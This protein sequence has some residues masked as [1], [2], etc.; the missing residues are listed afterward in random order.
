MMGHLRRL[1]T[2]RRIVILHH[3]GRLSKWRTFLGR[4]GSLQRFSTVRTAFLWRSSHT[5]WTLTSSGGAL[6]CRD[7]FNRFCGMVNNPRDVWR[8]RSIVQ[9][10]SDQSWWF[11]ESLD[12][13]L[14][15]SE[16]GRFVRQ[17]KLWGRHSTGNVSGLHFSVLAVVGFLN[18]GTWWSQ[19]TVLCRDLLVGADDQ[20]ITVTDGLCQLQNNS[21]LQVSE[22]SLVLPRI[23][24]PLTN[25]QLG[26]T[27]RQ[28][29]QGLQTRAEVEVDS[30]SHEGL[31]VGLTEPILL[32]ILHESADELSVLER[33]GTFFKV[34]SQIGEL[35]VLN[36]EIFE[37]QIRIELVEIILGRL[38]EEVIDD[39]VRIH[40]EL[41][42][43]LVF[44]L[45][46]T[47][48]GGIDSGCGVRS[49]GN[50]LEIVRLVQFRIVWHSQGQGLLRQWLVMGWR[51]LVDLEQVE[52]LLESDSRFSGEGSQIRNEDLVERVTSLVVK[53]LKL[54][55]IVVSVGS[56]RLEDVSV[57][58]NLPSREDQ[59]DGCVQINEEVV[60][61]DLDEDLQEL[62][63]HT[64]M[65]MRRQV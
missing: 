41:I 38:G 26:N 51:V 10:L 5:T 28:I 60:F 27:H 3:N 34:L 33:S 46:E 12:D 39:L 14:W 53:L 42:Q 43:K 25:I 13:L 49:H 35:L 16:D 40:L 32:E 47:V 8:Q 20:P 9:F 29:I 52:Q 37:I 24:E 30:I 45:G 58:A 48:V 54:M 19:V 55:Q 11:G 44:K 36:L 63:Q 59:I 56:T 2:S 50:Q 6:D 1:R 61:K 57:E 64:G 62:K 17:F 23:N 18:G 21:V 15:W 31:T 4:W 65:I 22:E 7:T